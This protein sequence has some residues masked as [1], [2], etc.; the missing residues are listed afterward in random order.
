MDVLLSD[1]D[2]VDVLSIHIF[3]YFFSLA[4]TTDALH[5]LN[6]TSSQG[7]KCP[8]KFEIVVML[9]NHSQHFWVNNNR[10]SHR[11]DAGNVFSRVAESTA[12]GVYLHMCNV[13]EFRNMVIKMGAATP[14]AKG[15]AI[16]L[17]ASIGSSGMTKF[18]GTSGYMPHRQH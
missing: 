10:Y 1:L 12:V 2:S 7:I 8:R 6:S 3:A 17:D 13:K 9:L 11:E 4:K 14:Y 15:S 5:Q 18:Q 16:T